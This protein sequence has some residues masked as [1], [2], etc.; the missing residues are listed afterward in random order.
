MQWGD[1]SNFTRVLTRLAANGAM[2]VFLCDSTRLL[3][4]PAG[5]GETL[6]M[7]LRH[8]RLYY[9]CINIPLNPNRNNCVTLAW[10]VCQLTKSLEDATSYNQASMKP[11][12]AENW[13]ILPK[14]LDLLF[15]NKVHSES[16]SSTSV[17]PSVVAATTTLQNFAL[18]SFWSFPTNFSQNLVLLHQVHKLQCFSC[19]KI[20]FWSKLDALPS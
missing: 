20:A 2:L 15:T 11:R 17:S 3:S 18:A 16:S 4:R 12:W 13:T 10:N 7:K 9:V 5:S 1:A 19:T 14:V 6:E 8:W